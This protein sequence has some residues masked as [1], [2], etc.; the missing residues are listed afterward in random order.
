MKNIA[1]AAFVL[2]ALSANAQKGKPIAKRGGTTAV[3]PLKTNN[4]SLSYALGVSIATFYKQQ[5]IKNLNTTILSK[6]VSDALGGKSLL[7]NETACNSI[8]MANMQKAEEDKSR[9]NV[10]A[11]KK[12]LDQNRLKSGVKTTAT[13]LQYE[14]LKEGSGAQPKATDTVVVNYVGTLLDGTEFDNSFKRGEPIEFALNRVIAGWTEGLQLM[15]PGA[16]YK[17]YVPHQLGYGL[18]TNGP[19]PGGSTLVFEVELLNVKPSK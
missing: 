3:K 15:S 10:D 1:V 2:F 9:P 19:I 17:F 16:K 18:N 8:I 5:G 11:G 13:G 7:L 14:V 4:D 6:A 12:F